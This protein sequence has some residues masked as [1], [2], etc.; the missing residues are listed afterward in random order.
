MRQHELAHDQYPLERSWATRMLAR[1]LAEYEAYLRTVKG[2]L[3]TAVT[4]DTIPGAAG[5]LKK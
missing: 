3:L 5:A 4:L 2:Y 1:N